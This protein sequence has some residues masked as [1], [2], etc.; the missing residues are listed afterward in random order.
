[1]LFLSR[2]IESNYRI[3][4]THAPISVKICVKFNYPNELKIV[5]I[6]YF[7]AMLLCPFQTQKLQLLVT[8]DSH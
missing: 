4:E 8:F 5:L 3:Y 2:L 7:M 1:M 6:T